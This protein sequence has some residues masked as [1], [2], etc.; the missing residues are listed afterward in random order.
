M[1]GGGGARVSLRRTATAS[2]RHVA[3]GGTPLTHPLEACLC[4]LAL[5]MPRPSAPD[6]AVRAQRVQVMG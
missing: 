5:C 6:G 4:L 3:T 2:L 1:V